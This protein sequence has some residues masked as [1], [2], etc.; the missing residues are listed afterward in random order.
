MS[1]ASNL[2][3]I[4]NTLPEN[5]KLVAVSKF[6]P[7]KI[8]QEAY[9]AGQRVFGESRVQELDTKQKN[10]PDDIEWHFIGHLQTNKIKYIVP[11]I[12]TIHSVDSWKLLTE[13]NKHAASVG[14]TINCL[15]EIYIAEEDTKYGLTFD[16]CYKLLEQNDFLSLNNIRICG[17]MGMASNTDDTNKIRSEFRSL[18]SFFHKVKDN[19]F[20]KNEYFAEMSIGMS[21]DFTIAIEEGS[22]MVRIG[23]SIFGQRD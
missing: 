5:V 13:I 7:S 15:L 2:K 23:S 21:H 1:V 17:L 12:H 22:T 19:F 10:L 8:L 18:K 16:E 6:H 11:Y 9:D 14:R 3:L 4:T 20:K